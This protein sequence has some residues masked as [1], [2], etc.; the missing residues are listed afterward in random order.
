MFE[1]VNLDLKSLC[2]IAE[3]PVK[4]MPK[5]RNLTLQDLEMLEAIQ[6][7]ASDGYDDEYV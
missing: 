3:K 7:R 2:R 4:P 6:P 5:G 1:D